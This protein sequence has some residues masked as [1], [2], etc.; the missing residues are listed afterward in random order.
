MYS[1]ITKDIQ[2]LI[3]QEFNIDKQ[4]TEIIT[5]LTLILFVLQ[6][7]CKIRI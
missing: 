5:K 4:N 3:V 2:N 7:N 6:K 1:L